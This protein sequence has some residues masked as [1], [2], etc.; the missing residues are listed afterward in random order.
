MK[1]TSVPY[2]PKYDIFDSKYQNNITW[3]QI[4]QKMVQIMILR[5]VSSGFIFLTPFFCH[6]SEFQV[7]TYNRNL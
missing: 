4:Y 5:Y 2:G 1:I 7:P 6:Y 3:K